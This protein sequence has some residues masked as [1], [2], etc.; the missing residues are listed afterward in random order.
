MLHPTSGGGEPSLSV[1]DLTVEFDTPQGIVRAVDGV[2]FDVFPGETVALV[3]E[4]GCG[5][6][7][8]ALAILGLVPRPAGRIAGGRIRC[9]GRNLLGMSNRELRSIRGAVASMVFQEPASSLNPVFTVG[10]QIAGVLRAHDRGLSRRAARDRVIELLRSVGVPDAASRIDDY[11]HQW[12]GGMCQRA[13]IAMA[14]AN[15]P[16]LLIADEP[17]TALDVTIQAQVLEVLD[18][19]RRETGA[20]TLLITHDLGVVAE[21]ADRVVVMY[22][23]RVIETATVDEIFHAPR[24]PYT[25]GLMASLP[26]LDIDVARLVP[27]PGQPPHLHRIPAGC[28]FHPR[29]R[30]RHGR[31]RCVEQSPPLLQ[32]GPTGR[33]TAC[34]F[35]DEMTTEVAVVTEEMG[36]DP[37]VA[38]TP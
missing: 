11:P 2:S 21:M 5:K 12:S 14:I 31:S 16:R 15:R 6:T 19:A 33:R 22:A 37:T 29:C 10:K 18:T 1:R 3:G 23:G 24:H 32:V 4:S 36:A 26:R 25:L 30:L 35:H 27:I 34:H 38:A 8:T 13:L 28:A 7:M 17:T 20:A 9:D